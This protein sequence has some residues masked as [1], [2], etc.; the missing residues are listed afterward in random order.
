MLLMLTCRPLSTDSL[1][2]KSFVPLLEFGFC[3]A[4]GPVSGVEENGTQMLEVTGL[5]AVRGDRRLFDGLGFVLQPGEMLYVN[6]PNGSGKTTLLRMLTGLLRPEQGDICW[7]GEAIRDL[8]DEYHRQLFY[9]GHLNAIKDELTGLENLQFAAQLSG[10]SLNEEQAL[11]ALIR[12]GLGGFEDLPSKVLSQGQKRRVAL[13]RLLLTEA[14][15]WILDEPFTALDT[16]AIDMLRQT[17]RE[18]L[19]MQGIVVMTTHQDVAIETDVVRQIR[20]G[21]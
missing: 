21:G 14:R 1:F 12:M 16:A 18:H 15:L 9:F 19:T 8:G 3:L 17:I 13:A 11:D 10:R 4:T 7:Q 6:G 2:A 5:E 20:M